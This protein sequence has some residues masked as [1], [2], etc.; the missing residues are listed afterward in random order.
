MAVEGGGIELGQQVN[1][2]QARI[3]AIGNGDVH[4][5]VFPGE[6]HGRFA[7]VP[8]QREEPLAPSAP[9]DDRENI[10]RID[11]HSYFLRHGQAP[12]LRRIIDDA[13]A[14]SKPKVPGKTLKIGTTQLSAPEARA[15]FTDF[16]DKSTFR[17]KGPKPQTKMINHKEHKDRKEKMP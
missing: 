10:A 16:T 13:R 4:Q 17:R 7:A 3:D 11:G 9:H 2:F 5:A 15:D 1:A 8:R 12:M 14:G 6:R